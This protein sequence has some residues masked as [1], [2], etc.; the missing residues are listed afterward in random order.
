MSNSGNSAAVPLSTSTISPSIPSHDSGK[1]VAL[2]TG[3]I[4]AQVEMQSRITQLLSEKATL[5]SQNDQLWRM[6]EKQRRVIQSLQ[7]NLQLVTEEKDKLSQA[8]KDL[9]FSVQVLLETASSAASNSSS[10]N[11]TLSS[12]NTFQTPAAKVTDSSNLTDS[13]SNKQ[14]EPRPLSPVSKLVL[15]E[16]L[17]TKSEDTA[18][19]N[20]ETS[21]IA[22][23][24]A[25]ERIL[26]SRLLS[27]LENLP[28]D[29][30]ASLSIPW[31][32]QTEALY[33][34]KPIKSKD[35]VQSK[36]NAAPEISTSPSSNRA[37]EKSTIARDTSPKPPQIID[38]IHTDKSSGSSPPHTPEQKTSIA[39]D[40]AVPNRKKQ[41]PLSVRFE[42]DQDVSAQMSSSPPKVPNGVSTDVTV[43]LKPKPTSSTSPVALHAKKPVP[44][45]NKS[46]RA[47]SSMYPPPKPFPEHEPNS[48]ASP[49]PKQPSPAEQD[50][51]ANSGPNA[52]SSPSAKAKRSNRESVF[53]NAIP[54]KVSPPSAA[55]MP[56]MTVTR[57]FL[58]IDTESAQRKVKDQRPLPRE[59]K[60]PLTTSEATLNTSTPPQQ[61]YTDPSRITLPRESAP[62]Q[63]PISPATQD[64]APISLG[65]V[66][67]IIVKVIGSTVRINEK[68]KEVLCFV[69]T[70]NKLNAA[71]KLE[72][73]WRVEKL[74][75]DFLALDSKIKRKENKSTP[76]SAIKLPDKSMF[77]S[78]V[79]S[80]VDQRK[81][82]LQKYLQHIVS[83]P[84]TDASDICE[85]LSTDVVDNKKNITAKG[86]GHKEGYL[87]K[88]GKNFGGWKKRYFVLKSGPVL[89]YFENKDGQWLG[90][91]KLTYSQIGRHLVPTD[92]SS[93]APGGDNYRH[94]F[95][96]LEPKRPGS[97][98][99]LRHILCAE[100]DEERDEW[101]NALAKWVGVPERTT[102]DLATMGEL[103][104]P[105]QQH[106]NHQQ[107]LQN[108]QQQQHR[109]QPQ[110]HLHPQLQQQHHHQQQ[111]LQQA[112]QKT[113]NIIPA[114]RAYFPSKDDSRVL[115]KQ[116]HHRVSRNMSHEESKD[117]PARSNSDPSTAAQKNFPKG[118]HLEPDTG[119]I[120]T[121]QSNTSPLPSSSGNFN[122]R[123]DGSNLRGPV[124]EQHNP[125]QSRYNYHPR[126]LQDQSG[127]PLHTYFDPSNSNN[128]AMDTAAPEAHQFGNNSDHGPSQERSATPPGMTQG[129]ESDVNPMSAL[130]K[131][132]KSRLTF[133]W[134]RMFRSESL[135]SAGP[136]S[137]SPQDSDRRQHS[138]D[139]LSP[140]QKIVFGVP[141][142]VAVRVS[143]VKEGYELP[144]VVYRCIEYLEAKNAEK[145]EGIYRLSGSS[146]TIKMLKDR[147]NIEGD[148]DLLGSGEYYD[149]HAI[150]GLLKLYLRELPTSVLTKDLHKDFMRVIDL[151]DRR[152]RVRELGRLVSA[153]PLANYTLLRALT[154][155][156][157]R[158]VQN[159][160]VNRMTMRNMGIVFSPSLGIPAGVFSL[161]MAEFDYIFYVNQD[162]GR[163]PKMLEDDEEE[164]EQKQKQ[165][166][167]RKENRQEERA[168]K[169]REDQKDDKRSGGRGNEDEKNNIENPRIAA[170]KHT[171]ELSVVQERG[172][173]MSVGGMF[174]FSKLPP[175]PPQSAPPPIPVQEL[176]PPQQP[177]SL[178]I[179][180][181]S[182]EE[183]AEEEHPRAPKL[184]KNM[185]IPAVVYHPS[186]VEA[187]A[188]SNGMKEIRIKQS[189]SNLPEKAVE[190]PNLDS[191]DS[192]TLSATETKNVGFMLDV[193]A[194]ASYS[195]TSFLGEMES[196]FGPLA[197]PK[198]LSEQA[199]RNNRNSLNYM[200]GAP[201]A[202]VGMEKRLSAADPL[203][204]LDDK[205]TVL[206]DLGLIIHHA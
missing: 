76:D 6:V 144:A 175:P 100:S 169:P 88:R 177:E 59:A 119:G 109:H 91:I 68:G 127:A 189:P 122:P 99:V 121:S 206:D 52:K 80:I 198:F 17:V 188:P 152:E 145:E 25:E 114:G 87:I 35:S 14:S 15:E 129:G 140:P 168:E 190:E 176:T 173:K 108:Y 166:N 187:V 134:P 95:L 24:K 195:S 85:F 161:L 63:Q 18:S 22:L 138:R 159:A 23:L 126:T 116:N 143:R 149:V 50:A 38:P 183:E 2:N 115:E 48:R 56:S 184:E 28:D 89:D 5:R 117:I 75:S 43:V 31:D 103:H 47:R 151:L 65:G 185:N 148:V 123:N 81:V 78:N 101:V 60:D 1:E 70:V 61:T 96:I 10:G 104:Q 58:E 34:N 12:G 33:R 165:A 26:D 128:P 153:L 164:Q 174:D 130:R 178:G 3:A 155:H 167:I 21:D 112:R 9:E 16:A 157:I 202:I 194:L 73:L 29:S 11:I 180:K 163:E 113:N 197:S 203:P 181:E 110:Q 132:Q 84:F 79:P 57:Q 83:L 64:E 135:S 136:G 37:S 205:E 92:V 125:Q 146:A 94:A 54:Y 204:Q 156:L 86:I 82:L 69:V 66:S 36:A 158:I 19:H 142:Q 77:N 170:K 27:I 13:T 71:G 200:D 39:S 46:S 45:Q 131:N 42:I 137:F 139:E 111:N 191:K 196:L 192:N 118:G 171:R 201:E 193:G 98:S 4:A 141:L 20:G 162:G 51:K 93:G 8:N 67:G 74:Y 154:A 120:V 40:G 105:N 32:S 150:A 182:W 179:I 55:E 124:A 41:G 147:F 72:E 199:Q 172:V 49:P 30:L 106:Q 7:A 160:N 102:S 44:S 186:V 133:A 53:L 90:S 107:R 97:S 62:K